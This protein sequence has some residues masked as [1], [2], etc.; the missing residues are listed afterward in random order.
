M[1][2]DPPG[3]R[4]T[5]HEPATEDTES[6]AETLATLRGVR[7]LY[8]GHPHDLLRDVNCEF[9]R[10]E[11]VMLAGANGSGKSTLLGLLSGRLRPTEG[12]VR[13]FGADPCRATRAP[14]LGL[15]TEPFHP[16]QSPL[17]V[18]FSGRQILRWL[19]ILDGIQQDVIAPVLE[20]LALAPRLLDVPMSRLSRGERQ[21]LALLTVLLRRPRLVLA[22]EPLEGIDRESRRLIGEVLHRYTRGD[23]RGVV[24][25]SHHLGED[26]RFADRL[27]EIRDRT[28]LAQS[29]RRFRVR[30][31]DRGGSVTEYRVGS[32]EALA[33]IADRGLQDS[34][35]MQIDITDTE[36]RQSTQ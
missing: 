16:E 35:D 14:D 10:G 12:I 18:D 36:R 24:W 22:D 32:L 17:P 1:S 13:V 2:P 28:V 29:G 5:A 33:G 19:A 27:L 11:V 34:P 23:G 25:I 8:H 15:V 9:R 3:I 6:G 4:P 21:R 31:T 30:A 7:F 20:E 26:S